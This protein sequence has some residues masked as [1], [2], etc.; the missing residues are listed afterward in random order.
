MASCVAGSDSNGATWS[1]SSRRSVLCTQYTAGEF[2][3][4]GRPLGTTQSMGTAG[5][6]PLT[7]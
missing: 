6:C 3:A 7:G 1:S 5:E 4:A 2:R